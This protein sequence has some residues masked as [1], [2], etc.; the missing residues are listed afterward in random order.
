MVRRPQMV[1]TPIR[2]RSGYS[3]ASRL[4]RPALNGSERM[5]LTLGNDERPALTGPGNRLPYHG[6][7][8]VF[9]EWYLCTLAIKASAFLMRGGLGETS[10]AGTASC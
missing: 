5:T 2:F 7:T 1:G 4:P 9:A 8:S 6:D 10:I 3:N